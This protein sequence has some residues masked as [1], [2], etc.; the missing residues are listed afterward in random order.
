MKKGYIHSFELMDAKADDK[1]DFDIV[2]ITRFTDQAQYE[3]AESNFQEIIRKSGGLKLL[4]ESKPSEFRQNVFVK[5][6]KSSLDFAAQ[7]P[8]HSRIKEIVMEGLLHPWSMACLSE[9]DALI[10]EKDG[11]LV[12]VNLFLSPAVAMILTFESRLFLLA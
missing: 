12:R 2:L 1:A 11:D 8:R 5:V 9:N 10:A 3:K 4:N 7:N 6:G